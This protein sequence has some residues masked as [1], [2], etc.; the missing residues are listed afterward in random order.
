MPQYTVSG[1]VLH[2]IMAPDPS[3]EGTQLPP[4][5][6]PVMAIYDPD[7]SPEDE[8]DLGSSTQQIITL[9]TECRDLLQ[10]I[11]TNTTP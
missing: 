3:V 2:A 6:V 9:L 8:E 7:L 4:R 10:T 1:G 5:L 11:V